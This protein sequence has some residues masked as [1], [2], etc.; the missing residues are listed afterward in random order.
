MALCRISLVGE[1]GAD[2]P[3]TAIHWPLAGAGPVPGWSGGWIIWAAFVFMS[4]SAPA[5]SIQNDYNCPPL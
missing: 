5:I 1:E 3:A 2:T 4:C